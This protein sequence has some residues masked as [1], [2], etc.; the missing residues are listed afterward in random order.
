MRVDRLRA[1]LVRACAS[2]LLASL[3]A[4][5][6]SAGILFT[7]GFGDGDRDNNG[8]AEAP[9]TDP[10]DVGVAWFYAGG[11]TSA[12]TLAAIDDSAGIGNG[13]ALQLFNSGSNNR[14]I[15]AQFAPTALNDGDRLVF[16]F[17]MRVVST[18]VTADRNFRFGLYTNAGTYLSGDQGST[19]TSYQD[20]VGYN[21]R[22]D[23]GPDASNSTSMDVTRDD[24]AAGTVIGGTATG[25][26][27]SSTNAVNQLVDN[28]KHHFE[29][30][31][32]RSA[33]GLLISLQ[34]DGNAA[35]SG[36]DATPV[37]G[38]FTFTEAM[39]STRSNAATDYRF[40]NIQV[41]YVPFVPEPAS[42]AAIGMIATG[43]IA[44]RRSRR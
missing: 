1:I 44:R 40:D 10:S 37:P 3:P 16:R 27:I 15:A 36:T 41:E 34:Q 11:G 14:P 35:I 4:A 7:D 9:V 17:D 24:S 28:A 2:L 25:L 12:A 6:A 38:N 31:L 21:C 19:D 39:L 5:T 33:T 8:T 43:L 13:N 29:L 22:V 42:I 26:G 32:T 23:V 30:S 20:D 18:S